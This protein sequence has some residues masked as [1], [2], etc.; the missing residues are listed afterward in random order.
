MRFKAYRVKDVHY[1]TVKL[2][3]TNDLFERLCTL[4]KIDDADNENEYAIMYLRKSGLYVLGTLVQSYHTELTKFKDGSSDKEEV[5][6][7]E[8]EINDKTIIYIDF[9][10]GIVYIQ[11][12]RYPDGLNVRLM[13]K[14]MED[15][16]SICFGNEV[17]LV[18]TEINNTIDQIEEVFKSS[19]VKKIVFKNMK[20]LELPEG[21]QLHNPRK[22]L[23][24]ALIESYNYYSKDTLDYMELRAKNGEDLHKNPFAKIGMTL[25]DEYQD[26]EIFSYMEILDNGEK[27]IIKKNGNDSKVINIS[28]KKQENSY[29]TYEEI[30]KKTVKGYVQE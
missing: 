2:G 6:I 20:G 16:F 17:V 21:S 12:K 3:D 24:D 26:K 5:K 8:P 4:P 23:D 10:D 19:I 9:V 7:A 28:K 18:E 11:S 22:E 29:E 30:L 25:T 27:I 14:R 13:K 1:Q 15:I